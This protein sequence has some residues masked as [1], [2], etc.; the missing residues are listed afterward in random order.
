MK[1]IE[2]IKFIQQEIKNILQEG[3]N[4]TVRL[5]S[6]VDVEFAEDGIILYASKKI[7]LTKD[8]TNKLAKALKANGYK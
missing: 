5:S 4:P 8:E 2:I 6:N 7:A 3:G 1:K